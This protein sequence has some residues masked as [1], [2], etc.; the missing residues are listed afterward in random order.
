[1]KDFSILLSVLVL[2][3]FIPYAFADSTPDW[4]KNTAGWWA[5]D[6]ISEIEFINAIEFLIDVGII[7]VASTTTSITDSESVPKWVKNTAGWWATD[8]I[9]EIEF[10]NAIE[11]LIDVGIV[12]ISNECKFENK[13][14][15]HITEFGKMILCKKIDMTFIDEII[16][17]DKRNEELRINKFGFR[18]DDFSAEKSENTFRIFIVGSSVA[19][20]QHTL[21]KDSISSHLQKIYD[22]QN[23]ETEI[24][25]INAGFGNAWSKTEVKWIRENIINFEPDLIIVL[26]GWTDVTRELVK[27]EDWTDDAN[28]ENWIS[29]WNDLCEFGNNNDFNTIITIQPILGSSNK[30]FTNQESMEFQHN[31]YQE[32]HLNLLEEYADNLEKLEPTCTNT[33]DLTSVYDG[34]FFPIY[35]DLGHVNSF[36]SKII[37]N[38]FFKLSI[39][40]VI[41]DGETTKEKFLSGIEIPKYYSAEMK[42]S[43]DDLSGMIFSNLKLN[44]LENKRFWWT[45]LYDIEISN[46]EISNNDF[47]FSHL[48]GVNFQG[49]ELEN[50]K[51][52]RSLIDG[53]DFSFMKI[54]DTSFSTTNIVNTNFDNS[55]LK[56]IESY[57]SLIQ[58]NS[59]TNSIINDTLFKRA[60]ISNNDFSNAKFEN[61]Q[62]E[63]TVL[64]GSDFS[65][66]DFG[67]TQ[68]NDGTDFS[69]KFGLNENENEP[70]RGAI[71]QNSDFRETDLKNVIFSLVSLEKDT[72]EEKII[73]INNHRENYAVDASFV[74]FSNLD[75]ANKNFIAMNFQFSN[76]SFV[77][78]T[79]S[80]L[81]Y[82]D[83]SG[84]NLEGAN[85]EGAN[86]EGA[87]LEGANLEGANMKC[88]NHIMCE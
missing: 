58:E 29:R 51:I 40:I 77:D 31:P 10:I 13:E 57:G 68:F 26:D 43:E 21:E 44:S 36:G 83:L 81:R 5:T 4:V 25:V 49:S 55:V 41:E 69:A 84:A 79:N 14:F 66:V 19:Y 62:F 7:Q 3:V 9:S 15:L 20:G 74:N 47:R 85:L 65:G 60:I 33:A 80:D 88:I 2:T 16:L 86:L 56:N 87:N 78:L 35:F 82:S 1:M 45:N 37:A 24:E 70:V 72:S 32:L 52:I 61:I 54:S 27:N 12:N 71:L 38:E 23:L 22:E 53:S 28:V 63:S 67:S 59:F 18:G 42:N 34:Y 30:M 6:A 39:P 8:A 76:M 46:S 50:T 73:E 64:A 11:F 75:L 17:P 48:N